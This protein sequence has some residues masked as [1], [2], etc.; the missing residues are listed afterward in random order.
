[1]DEF[2]VYVP[3]TRDDID[4]SS[5]NITPEWADADDTDAAAGPVITHSHLDSVNAPLAPTL[6][7]DAS[8]VHG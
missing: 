7:A 8:A 4:S 3:M 6:S 1:M 2:Q 5:G